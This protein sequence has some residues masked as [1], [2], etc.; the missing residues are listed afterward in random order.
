MMTIS[1]RRYLVCIK[2]STVTQNVYATI[3][4]IR[5]LVRRVIVICSA[6]RVYYNWWFP[7][8]HLQISTL[9]SVTSSSYNII[10]NRNV[11]IDTQ[12]NEF[13]DFFILY[14]MKSKIN[15]QN[16]YLPDSA[17]NFN[18]W[19]AF[20]FVLLRECDG[21]DFLLVIPDWISSITWSSTWFSLS[22]L[23]CCLCICLNCSGGGNG[24]TSVLGRFQENLRIVFVR[25]FNAL[26]LEGE[27]FWLAGWTLISTAGWS[28]KDKIKKL[29]Y[30]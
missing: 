2:F 11:Y 26:N 8:P 7:V 10:Y 12:M 22:S 29:I 17:F 20:P 4:M 18:C 13:V 23:W 15:P 5:M 6:T 16:I 19:G 14:R 30:Y 9:I 21:V 3:R 24:P 1:I 28:Y 25:L 27:E